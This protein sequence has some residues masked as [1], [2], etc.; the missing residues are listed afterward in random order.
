MDIANGSE[1]A[2]FALASHLDKGLVAGYPDKSKYVTQSHL[3]NH[4]TR[5]TIKQCLPNAREELLDFIL[6]SAVKIFAILV[7]RRCLPPNTSLE[8]ALQTCRDVHFDDTQ[9]PL[10][11]ST[12]KCGCGKDQAFCQHEVAKS[13]LPC[14]YVWRQFYNTQWTFLALELQEGEF[15]YDVHGCT[16]LPIEL[17]HGHGE[18]SFSNVKE[19]ELNQ[20]HARRS[21]GVSQIVCK[22]FTI[23]D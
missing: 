8:S 11:E 4:I 10:P 19:G 13:I 2:R 22:T 5:T 12:E 16:I 18:G 7:Y 17:R 20:D 14:D 3:Q 21:D 1:E 6:S 15:D 9:L 23:T